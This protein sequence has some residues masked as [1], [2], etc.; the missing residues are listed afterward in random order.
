VSAS[1]A[2]RVRAY[3]SKEK[4]FG[5][6]RAGAR[7]GQELSSLGQLRDA[8]QF[9]RRVLTDDARHPEALY[10]LGAACHA[11]GRINEAVDFFERAVSV[12]TGYAEARHHLGVAL[13]Q[14]GRL[15]EAVGQLQEANRLRPGAAEFVQSLRA[16]LAAHHLQQAAWLEEQGRAEEAAGH[17]REAVAS[18]PENVAAHGNLGNLLKSRGQL[19]EASACF[20]AFWSW[21]PG[22]HSRTTIWD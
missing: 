4:T 11:Q 22:W 21:R 2:D 6:Y 8:E 16:A 12:Q 14:Q 13:A 7:P 9:Y 17:Y 10:L 15:A 5:R 18:Q 3:A 1:A 19:D 20:R